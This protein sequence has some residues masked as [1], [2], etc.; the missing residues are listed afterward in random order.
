MQERRHGERRIHMRGAVNRT[1]AELISNE[2]TE[3]RSPGTYQE[4][5]CGL[6]ADGYCQTCAAYVC[7]THWQANHSLH[8]VA[9][10]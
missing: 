7:T 3:H 9:R 2:G 1:C 8:E 6:D 10:R 5:E 4:R